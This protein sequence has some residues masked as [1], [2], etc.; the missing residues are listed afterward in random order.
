MSEQISTDTLGPS[1]N[2]YLDQIEYFKKIL[3]QEEA[4]NRLINNPD[5]KEIILEGFCEKEALECNMMRN[6]HLAED[7]RRQQAELFLNASSG[8]RLWLRA[9]LA[10]FAGAHMQIDRAQNELQAANSEE[11]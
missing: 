11:Q 7:A 1:Q 5:F 6:D 8:F 2:D 10:T 4:F 9:K 3:K